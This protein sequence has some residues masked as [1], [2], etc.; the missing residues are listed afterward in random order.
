M[1]PRRDALGA[2]LSERY[3]ALSWERLIRFGTSL[4]FISVYMLL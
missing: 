2:E 4:F 1:G 3:S